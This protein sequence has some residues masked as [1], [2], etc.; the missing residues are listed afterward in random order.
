MQLSVLKYKFPSVQ[1]SFYK[2]RSKTKM[3]RRKSIRSSI[4]MTNDEYEERNV[5]L[6]NVNNSDYENHYDTSEKSPTSNRSSHSVEH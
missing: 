4:K 6:R 5:N 1:V 3:Q 2:E